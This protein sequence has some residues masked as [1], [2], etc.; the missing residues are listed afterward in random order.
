[1]SPRR[2]GAWLVA[3]LWSAKHP[4]PRSRRMAAIGKQRWLSARLGLVGRGQI[5]FCSGSDS[6]RTSRFRPASAAARCPDERLRWVETG[7]SASK[8]ELAKAD[9]AVASHGFRHIPSRSRCSLPCAIAYASG[10]RQTEIVL[11]PPVQPLWTIFV[12]HDHLI[13]CCCRG[14]E[15][16]H[17]QPI[18]A[19]GRSRD[20]RTGGSLSRRRRFWTGPSSAVSPRS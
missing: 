14:S 18:V 11:S 1:M 9:A 12:A 13:C 8:R 15:E 10:R 3:I 20:M 16:L 5:R 2:P 17:S 6:K 4:K 19:E 7:S